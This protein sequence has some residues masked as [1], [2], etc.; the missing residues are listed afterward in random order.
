MEVSV[1]H[2]PAQDGKDRVWGGCFDDKATSWF[3]DP[4][5]L[6]EEIGHGFGRDVFRDPKREDRVEALFLEGEPQSRAND[7]P[8]NIPQV[9]PTNEPS[10]AD[11]QADG[12][13][14]ESRETSEV[15]AEIQHHSVNPRPNR[16]NLS[17]VEFLF[18][19]CFVD[20]KVRQ[21]AG[22]PRRSS[23]LSTA[24]RCI[25]ADHES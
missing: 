7:G 11:V 19:D 21:L 9:D 3:G 15:S 12:G 13:G 1:P 23:E 4:S 5:D 17:L 22:L 25:T 16:T 18:R 14:A 8:L 20:A 24:R 6:I 2:S 10:F